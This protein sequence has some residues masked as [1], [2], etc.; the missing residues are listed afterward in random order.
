VPKANIIIPFQVTVPTIVGSATL[1]S[2]QIDITM[3]DRER[4]ALRR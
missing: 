1:T 4:I 3:P 2:E